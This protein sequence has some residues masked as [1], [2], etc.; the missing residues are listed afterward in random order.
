MLNVW[1]LSFSVHTNAFPDADSNTPGISHAVLVHQA[2]TSNNNSTSTPIIA[3]VMSP[4]WWPRNEK[5]LSNI[6]VTKNAH[7]IKHISHF[8][9]HSKPILVMVPTL[10]SNKPY[11][12]ITTTCGVADDSRFGIVKTLR[13][14][15]QNILS[16]N[17]LFG[18]NPFHFM[19][20]D[21][22]RITILPHVG[23]FLC[24]LNARTSESPTVPST[25]HLCDL[26]TQFSVINGVSLDFGSLYYLALALW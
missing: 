25:F 20:S 24:I 3:K 5:S 7:G 1:F 26:A 12:F 19:F 21:G 16:E 6:Y 8:S 18:R 13:F 4:V 17:N 15:W 14:Q 10:S 11:V 23:R 2:I 22:S 9:H